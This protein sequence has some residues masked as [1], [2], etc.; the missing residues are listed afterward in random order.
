MVVKVRLETGGFE[1]G[2]F[3]TGGFETSATVARVVAIV[4]TI[5]VL[6][7]WSTD[8]VRFGRDKFRRGETVLG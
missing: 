5:T 4:G 7:G 1:T 6:E 8:G 3:E 2:G